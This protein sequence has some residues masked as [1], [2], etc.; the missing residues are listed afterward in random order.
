MGT[1][2]QM[3][4][5]DA[6]ILVT[7]SNVKHQLTGSEY[8]TRV[9]QCKEA[10]RLLAVAFPEVKQLRD[11]TPGMLEQVKAT[12]D[13]ETYRRARHVIAENAR[14]EATVGALQSGDFAT[15]GRHMRASHD[16]LRDDFEVSVPELDTLVDLAM[17]YEGVFGSRMTGGGFGGCIVTLVRADAAAG[18]MAYLAARYRQ[19]TALAADSFV[20]RP[21]AGAGPLSL[22]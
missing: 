13:D 19:A 5:S 7:N 3:G 17:A 22:L 2:V 14:V 15:V 20:T 1:K 12:M 11:A 21:G 18:L 6:V 16:S 8:P 4:S 10:T 9:A